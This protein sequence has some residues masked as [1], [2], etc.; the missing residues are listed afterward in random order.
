MIV[1]AYTVAFYFPIIIPSLAFNV[2]HRRIDAGG[3]IVR[4]S[5]LTNLP[6]PLAEFLAQ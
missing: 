6:A 3:V 5:R 2:Y 4:I 1:R